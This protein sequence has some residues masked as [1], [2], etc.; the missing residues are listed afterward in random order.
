VGGG[1]S[2]LT[3][4]DDTVWDIP[5]LVEEV[6]GVPMQDRRGWHLA[7][8][9][10]GSYYDLFGFVIVMFTFC[11]QFSFCVSLVFAAV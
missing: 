1:G 8:L 10:L 11:S 7:L 5:R 9:L 3:D 6:C 2:C 4:A